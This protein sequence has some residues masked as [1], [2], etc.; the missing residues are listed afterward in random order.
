MVV[1]D[2][3]E[4]EIGSHT[5]AHADMTQ[6]SI[7]DAQAEITGSVE[8]IESEI[9]RKVETFCFPYSRSSDPLHRLVEQSG[10]AA[11]LTSGPSCLITEESDPHGLARIE[12]DSSQTLLKLRTSGAYPALSQKLFGGRS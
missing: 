12:V 11:G 1:R 2:F 6:L 10:L 8:A 3:P 9:D 5:M 4:F 7:R